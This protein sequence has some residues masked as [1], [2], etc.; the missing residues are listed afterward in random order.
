MLHI[1]GITFPIF[2]LIA[3]GYGV[4]AKGVFKPADMR[5]FG[6]YVLNI[7]MPAMLFHAVSSS[8]ISDV[9]NTGYLSA[10]LLGGLGT[11]ALA[12][13]VFS[14]TADGPNRRAIGVMGTACCNSALVG[15]PVMLLVFPDIAAS[16]LAMNVIIENIFIIP[17][18][19]ML[20]EAARGNGTHRNPVIQTLRILAGVFRRPMIIGMLLGLAVSISGISLPD[21]LIR[22]VEMVA[23]STVAPALIAI[24]GSLVGLS[25]RGSQSLAAQIV[26]G[27]LLVHPLMTA[28]FVAILATAG[29]TLEGDLR[30]AVILSASVPIFVTYVAFA[31]EAGHEGLASIAQL[32]GTIAA[33]LTLNAALAI[34]T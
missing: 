31:Q 13:A 5:I 7:A 22:T 24:G 16:V 19:L 6:G 23:R 9:F 25:T 11:M 32:V 28:A 14:F 4:T 10:Y 30:A 26:V 33:F 17:A 8:P 34:L 2:A 29:I 20:V 1:L 27:K 15:Y 12:Y 18:S 21:P 3:L